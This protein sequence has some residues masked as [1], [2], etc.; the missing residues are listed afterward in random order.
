M[1]LSIEAQQQQLKKTV[2]SAQRGAQLSTS[3][4]L[5][6]GFVIII[7]YPLQEEAATLRSRAQTTLLL[8]WKGQQSAEKNTVARAR[9]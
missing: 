6:P 4:L 3:L 9:S 2:Q 7:S 1:A 8:L 5:L